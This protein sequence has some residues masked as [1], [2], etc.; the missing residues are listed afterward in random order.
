[1]KFFHAALLAVVALWGCTT[2]HAQEEEV[3]N[4]DQAVED[5]MRMGRYVE[6]F[7]IAESALVVAQ[8]KYGK[9]HL[10][11]VSPMKNLAYFCRKL[12]KFDQA[13]TLYTRANEI[14]HLAQSSKK[15]LFG[16]ADSAFPAF[17]I[18]LRLMRDSQLK[19]ALGELLT[20]RAELCLEE[21]RYDDGQK[22]LKAALEN[23]ER[24]V[25]AV[26]N[27]YPATTL[28]KM[29]ML[30]KARG[31]RLEADSLYDRALEILE[32]YPGETDRLADVLRE[33]AELKT[34]AGQ[35]VQA[36]SLY[37]RALHACEN[38][39][40]SSCLGLGMLLNELGALYRALGL[41]SK[42]ETC[43]RRS[44]L[45]KEKL[46]GHKHPE[47]AVSLNSLAVLYGEEG[48]Y[49]EAE[50]FAEQAVSIEEDAYGPEHPDLASMLTNLAVQ[51]VYLGRYGEAEKNL[52]RAISILEKSEASYLKALLISA[53]NLT[54]LYRVQNRSADAESVYSALTARL[55]SNRD[56][57]FGE[58]GA[59]LA[60]LLIS[61]AMERA[62]QGRF[63][64]TEEL[65]ERA[66]SL[67]E[68]ASSGGHYGLVY[69]FAAKATVMMYQGK[70][71]QAEY[72]FQ[73]ALTTGQ[74]S[75]NKNHPLLASI[76]NLDARAFERQGNFSAAEQLYTKASQVYLEVL[77]SNFPYLSEREKLAFVSSI[78]ETFE[79]LNSFAHRRI[80]ANPGVVNYVADVRLATKGILIDATTT[81][82]RR[83]RRS[84]DANLIERYDKWVSLREQA[85]KAIFAPGGHA[86][87]SHLSADSLDNEANKLEKELSLRSEAFKSA[88]EKKRITWQKVRSVLKPREA[89]IEIIRFRLYDER[90]TDTVYYAALIVTP[91]TKH[92]PDIVVLENGNELEGVYLGEYRET[93][94][95]QKP[96]LQVGAVKVTEAHIKK[97][98]SE[99][100]RQY[101]QKIQAKLKGIK[102]VYLS[103][104]GVYDQINLLTLFNPETGRYLLEDLDIQIVT[105]T[106]DLVSYANTPKREVKNTA[107]L[108]GYPNYALGTQRHEQL[109]ANYQ[110]ERDVPI[111]GRTADS[112]DRYTLTDLPGTKKEVE[113]IEALLK[114]RGWETRKHLGD[115][116]LE[117]VVKAVSSPRVLV[118]STHGYFL[119]DVQR[120]KEEGMLLGMQAER[121]IENPL[122]R[123][124]LMLAGAQESLSNDSAVGSEKV[125]NGILTAYEAMNL[126]LDN[127]ELVV[128]SACETGLGEVKNG[129]GVYGLQRAF[130]VAGARTVIMSLWKV[131]DEA[132][133]KLMTAFF[134]NWLSGMTKQEAFKK[135][136]LEVKAQYPESYYWGA[137]VMVG[138]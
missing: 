49:G 18:M 6:G 126:D 60:E 127:T 125:D 21:A 76:M 83:I 23:Q 56:E 35:F 84:K 22:F 75:L 129:E 15:S 80:A 105:N 62:R 109:A 106:K 123:S 87:V 110:R 5:A 69:L 28:M 40:D 86:A 88:F 70:S 27:P 122:L 57:V 85:G 82:N 47:I 8:E 102:K 38:A 137:F 34:Q 32:G 31:N 96:R 108:F 19:I 50:R 17:G 134:S 100:Y 44:L 9:D 119:E 46:F 131:S 92:H 64:E 116:A 71:E 120:A 16:E 98:L 114:S 29:G 78:E 66:Q 90:W 81:M 13:E 112:L 54:N 61:E 59:G 20:E 113:T 53:T 7:S 42:A 118:I 99:L 79:A 101:W 115:D 72:F 107:E 43:Y 2:T 33:K 45:V 124:G 36:E 91:E 135:A 1:M 65:F 63:L 67:Y 26:E 39:P 68:K 97:I 51:R 136:Q 132:T 52:K 74:A 25:L 24:A 130:Q 41:L 58:A 94:E 133:Q 3:N 93:I 121:V 103:L 37:V 138:E 4:L 10:E 73:E 95:D 104:D 128:L 111:Y 89:A 11:L 55:L 77:R 14:I 30:S 48:R 12:R 117:E